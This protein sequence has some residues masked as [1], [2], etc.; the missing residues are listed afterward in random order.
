MKRTAVVNVV[1]CWIVVCILAAC[2]AWADV[3]P[4]PGD[5]RPRPPRPPVLN[6]DDTQISITQAE[7]K[8]S[9]HRH[10]SQLTTTVVAS[11]KL[12]FSQGSTPLAHFEMAMPVVESASAPNYRLLYLK[13]DGKPVAADQIQKKTW[14][15]S[16]TTSYQGFVWPATMSRGSA[17]NVTIA[18]E[19][20][21]KADQK[22]AWQVA[23]IL[24]SGAKWTGT[25]G[26]ETVRLVPEKG[27]QLRAAP[28]SIKSRR[29]ADGSIVWEIENQ[30]PTND[31]VAEVTPVQ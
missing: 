5:K 22:G 24:K 15:A 13:V 23:Y 16:P 25:I 3:L 17:Q 21:Q 20:T 9:L 26:H 4:Y 12:E 19:L 18:Y 7:V 14:P 30:K 29:E 1:L 28:S 6:Q 31:A 8:I 2:V 10:S 27:L 11:F